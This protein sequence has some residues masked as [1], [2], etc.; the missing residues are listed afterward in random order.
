MPTVNP[1]TRESIPV[2]VLYNQLPRMVRPLSV[3]RTVHL[4][5]WGESSVPEQSGASYLALLDA[6]VSNLLARKSN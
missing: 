2:K 1:T 6:R 5:E 3:L 4:S